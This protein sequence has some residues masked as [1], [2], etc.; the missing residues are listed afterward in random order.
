MNEE[1]EQTEKKEFEKIRCSRCNSV[2]GYIRIKTNK[3]V[4]R[5]CG[6]KEDMAVE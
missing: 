6:Y 4:C 3:W 5:K 2:F 1:K